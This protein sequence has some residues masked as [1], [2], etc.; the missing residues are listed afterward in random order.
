[1]TISD[2]ADLRTGTKRDSRFPD[3]GKRLSYATTLGNR[4]DSEV[5]NANPNVQV[6][7]AYHQYD[8]LQKF[9][10][11]PKSDVYLS[12][13]FQFS[14][15]GNL[16]RYDNL[17]EIRNGHL[18]YSEWSYRPQTR[19]LGS[20]QFKNY[21]PTPLYDQYIITAAYQFIQENRIIRNFGSRMR[22]NQNEDVDVKSFSAEIKKRLAGSK[23]VG[24]HYGIDLQDNDVT[25]TAFNRDISTGEISQEVL[26]RYADGHNDFFT[27]GIFAAVEINPGK[28]GFSH[29]AGLRYSGARYRIQYLNTG[30]IEWPF[31]FRE[32]IE[33]TNTSLT[34]SISSLYRHDKGWFA[35]GL[36]S[37]A[38]RSP[39]ID[40]LSK[41][42]VN[43]DE[44]TFP[45]PDLKPERSTGGEL[46]LGFSSDKMNFSSTAFYT[47]L[48]D[49]IV[50]RSFSTPSGERSYE[51]FGEI[52]GVVA[53]Q[54]VQ[55]AYIY[56]LSLNLNLPVFP[57]LE[58]SSSINLTKGKERVENGEDLPFAHIPPLYGQSS[59]SFEKEDWLLKTSWVFNGMKSINDFGGSVDNPELATPIGSLAWSTFNIYAQYKISPALSG[60]LA[61][62]NIF[63]KHYRPFSSGLSAPGRNFIMC[64]RAKFAS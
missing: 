54:N 25:S 40:D 9:I 23:K 21:H 64:L 29:R 15:T 55:S 35:R 2:Y 51:N 58:L 43:S 14:T 36:V 6:G 26:S 27:Y 63:D 34:W 5:T 30:I 47:S 11:K 32:G 4:E 1:M 41:I 10:F 42:R 20:L 18:R 62:E 33:N 24:L 12:A 60:S 22:Q 31:S 37:S 17:Q 59:L 46:S 19:L 13:N 3:F 44:I 38:F 57:F 28:S 53:N 48:E 50:Q 45:N 56:G 39:N 7:T 16:P 49:A 8:V 52:L 61:L